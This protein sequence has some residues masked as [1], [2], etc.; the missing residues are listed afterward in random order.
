M[1]N[2]RV[3]STAAAVAAALA[4]PGLL[5]SA[6]AQTPNVSGTFWATEYHPKIQLVGGG[7]LPLTAEG[8]AAYEKNIAGLKDGSITDNAR[9]YCVPDGLPR[10]LATALS[11]R[12]HPRPARADH[13]GA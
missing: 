7:E 4:M 9:K 3:Y 13:D 11:V 8:K 1:E 10:V 2:L 5:G 6:N 12:D